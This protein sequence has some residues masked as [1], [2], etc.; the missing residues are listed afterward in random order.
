[1]SLERDEGKDW[2][3]VR[4]ISLGGQEFVI[5]KLVL[6]QTIPLADVTRA[7]VNG[8]TTV[9]ALPDQDGNP[10]DRAL[11]GSELL[12]HYVDAIKIGL[13]RAYLKVTRDDVLDLSASVDEMIVAT[14]VII[15]Q[16]GGKKTPDKP[17]ELVA[18][19]DSTKLTGNDS[20]PA[21]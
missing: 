12:D 11:F 8:R 14:L 16:A 6:R 20:S 3:G 5:P 9:V 2:P 10:S 1:M 17:G 13:S 7:I 15:E 18:T 21:S 4:T 19:S